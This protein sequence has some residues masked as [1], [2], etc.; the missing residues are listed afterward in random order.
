[1]HVVVHFF[2]RHGLN[3]RRGVI[4]YLLCYRVSWDMELHRYVFAYQ[5][6]LCDVVQSIPLME[7]PS[8]FVAGAAAID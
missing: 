2:D 8:A 3:L 4:W 7:Y 1:M 5:G 6:T